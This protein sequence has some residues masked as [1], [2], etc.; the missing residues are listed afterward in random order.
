MFGRFSAL[1][2]RVV[3]APVAF[4]C[5]LAVIV[6]WALTGPIFHF[7][8]TWQL[9]INTG[10]TIV[11]FLIGFCITNQEQR[12]ARHDHVAM[13]KLVHVEQG[14]G[15]YLQTLVQVNQQQLEILQQQSEIL[16]LLKEKGGGAS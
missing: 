1:V 13:N 5:A 11:T 12:S 15:Q 16:D 4:A 2:N 6:A 7:S 10:T 14:H 9:V 8:D 3:G